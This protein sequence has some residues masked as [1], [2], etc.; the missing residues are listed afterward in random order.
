MEKSP[1]PLR[2]RGTSVTI[3]NRYAKWAREAADDGWGGEDKQEPAPKTTLTLDA[4]KSIIARNDS[5]DLPFDRSINPYRGC[6][7]GCIYCY[8]RPSHAW[9]GWSPGLEFETRLTYKADAAMRLRE[10]LAKPG[11][12]PAPLALGANTDAWQPAEKSWRVTRQVLEVLAETNHPVTVITKSALILRDLDLL[13]PMAAKGLAQVAI[14]V[15]TLDANLARRLEPRAASPKRRLEIIRMLR[16][17]GIKPHIMVAPVIPG[18]TDHEPESILEAVAEAGASY[19]DYILLR[20]PL[21]VAPLFREWLSSHYPDR[22]GHVMSLVEQMRD[23]AIN[24]T[25][26]GRRL[27]GEGP[28]AE[29]LKKRFDLARRRLGL[30]LAPPPIDCTQFRPPAQNGQGSLF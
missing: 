6:E 26:F 7:H 20:L 19:A 25:R 24:D 13:A 29:L 23:G 15:T 12:R 10:E 11:Y 27:L 28:L 14:S 8:A 3:D 30:T 21:E 16:D 2:G 22:A 1:P 5:P 4:S 9:L 17:A 18:L